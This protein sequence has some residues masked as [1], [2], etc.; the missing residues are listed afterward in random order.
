VGRFPTRGAAPP[1][2]GPV[3]RS[4][5]A[6][7]KPE[8]S[9]ECRALKRLHSTSTSWRRGAAKPSSLTS[10][11]GQDWGVR[12]SHRTA[13]D[14]LDTL[15]VLNQPVS[16]STLA[17]APA[18]ASRTRTHGPWM[19]STRHSESRHRVPPLKSIK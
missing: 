8:S 2:L 9:M 19:F 3:T 17:P 7:R 6:N 1:L 13:S 18:L 11:W 12:H 15:A 5:Y 16:R 4:A 14:I 10:D